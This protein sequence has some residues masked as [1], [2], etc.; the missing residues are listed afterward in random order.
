MNPNQNEVAT[1][2]EE[3]KDINLLDVLTALVEEKLTFF[4]VI[5]LALLIGL[6]QSLTMTPVFTARTSFLPAQQA[7]ANS[8]LTSLSGL[9]SLSSLS[10]LSNLPNLSGF[11]G[12]K[13]SE[14]LYIAYMRSATVQSALIQKLSLMDR[15]KAK[16]LADARMA[17]DSIVVI[18]VEKKSGLI[19][20]MVEDPDPQFAAQLANAQVAELSILLNR[21][22]VTEA[23]NRRVY[24]ENEV[25]KTQKDLLLAEARF[26]QA[27]EKSGVQV[28]MSMIAE[29]GI[30]THLDL[31]AQIVGREIQLQTLARYATTRNPEYQRLNSEMEV[32][33]SELRKY[34]QGTG[35]QTAE[36]NPAKNE[37]MQAYRDL[38]IQE[39]KLDSYVRQLESARI[40]ESKE[41]PTVQILDV[42]LPPDRRS[43][44]ERKKIV[45]L[46]LLI[47]IALG[48]VLALGKAFVKRIA[49][50]PE[51]RQQLLALKA[52]WAPR[53]GA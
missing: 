38:K 15:F 34:E 32:L 52:A 50:S 25:E 7:G 39:S 1:Q 27:Q 30:R 14:D 31:R 6:V 53:R 28:I 9:S 42:A 44:P 36:T 24:F 17:L 35:R 43:K 18:G 51:G 20:V 33:K 16:T 49:S 2:P 5:F 22:V 46:A 37:A 8:M 40:D 47:G 26:R 19:Y 12:V 10:G 45:M 23:Q 3:E 48:F 29:S 13:T 11:G 41:G 4:V 21:L